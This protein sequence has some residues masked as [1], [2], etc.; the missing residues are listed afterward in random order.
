ME[1]QKQ[2]FDF[3]FD[4]EQVTDVPDGLTA[5]RIPPQ[6]VPPGFNF[7]FDAEPIQGVPP[8]LTAERIPPQAQPAPGTTGAAGVLNKI[9]ETGAN[10]AT[11]FVKG[12]GD[13]VSGV[14]HLLNKVPLIGETLA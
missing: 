13:T 11:G 12:L 9:G 6:P 5:E 2:G 10:V 14:S 4:T 3:G 8:G 7:G 1:E